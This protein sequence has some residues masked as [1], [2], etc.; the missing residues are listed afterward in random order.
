MRRNFYFKWVCLGLCFFVGYGA[1]WGQQ[2]ESE[3]NDNSNSADV[4]VFNQSISGTIF[5]EGDED[6]FE[7]CVTEPGVLKV[8]GTDPS[9]IIE[10][11]VD[12]ISPEPQLSDLETVIENNS[13]GLLGYWKICEPGCY[14]VRAYDSGF[15]DESTDSYSITLSYNQDDIYECNESAGVSATEIQIGETIQANIFPEGD[16]DVFKV[17]VPRSGI[18]EISATNI[19]SDNLDFELIVLDENQN[20]L[21]PQFQDNNAGGFSHA[22]KVCEAGC[23]YFEIYDDGGADFSSMLFDFTVGFNTEDILECNDS[24]GSNLPLLDCDTVYASIYPRYSVNTGSD[25]D[26]YR[27]Q[28]NSAGVYTFKVFDISPDVDF[29]MKIYDQQGGQQG[30]TMS[31]DNGFDII[32]DVPLPSSGTYL[33]EIYDNG[34][35]DVSA[36]LY[37]LVVPLNFPCSIGPGGSN[38]CSVSINPSSTSATCNQNDGT[39][40]LTTS[41]GTAPY[42]YV[43]NG[44]VNDS[45]NSSSTSV[46][47]SNLPSG[48]YTAQVTD[49]E[50]CTASVNFTITSTG[51]PVVPNF[52]YTVNGQD[53]SFD[54]PLSSLDMVDSLEWDF[55]DGTASND[56]FS[57]HT[58]AGS[59]PYTVS[60]QFWNNCG[61]DTHDQ[62]VSLVPSVPPNAAFTTSSNKGCAPFTV[63]FDNTSTNAIEYQWIIE[64]V[65]PSYY[66]TE[67]VGNITFNTPGI[68]TV[69]L[70]AENAVGEEDAATRIIEVQELPVADF[71]VTVMGNQA[72][73]TN[74]SS[75]TPLI[76]DYSWSFGD[77]L[78]STAINPVH[79]YQQTGFYSVE[80]SASNT[81]GS[82]TAQTE[83]QA[84]AP[85]GIAT[86][87]I[88]EAEGFEGTTVQ[89][90]VVLSGLNGS[91]LASVQGTFD[92]ED[93]SVGNI[94]SISPALLA[95]T[96]IDFNSS[97]DRFSA[98]GSINTNLNGQ[99]TLFYLEVFL[100]GEPGDTSEITISTSPNAGTPLE[101]SVFE[102]GVISFPDPLITVPGRVSIY[103]SADVDGQVTY[104]WNGS[105]VNFTEVNLDILQ[106]ATTPD[107]LQIT[108]PDGLYEFDNVDAGND[109]EI[110]CFKDTNYLNGVSTAPL[111]LI[112]E[113]IVDLDTNILSS[114]YQLVAA[115]A[116]CDRAVT[117]SDIAAFQFLIVG[118]TNS[119]SCGA[120]W[121]FIPESYPI[122]YANA[123]LYPNEVLFNDILGDLIAD[124]IGVKLGDLLGLA[125][126]SNLTDGNFPE[127]RNTTLNLRAKDRSL[128]AG[129]PFQIQLSTDDFNEIA[130]LQFALDYATSHLEFLGFES[131]DQALAPVQHHNAEEGSIRLSWLDQAANGV[132]LPDGES[133]FTL[134]FVAHQPIASLVD[135]LWLNPNRLRSEAMQA[136]GPISDVQ[137]QWN[138]PTSI[139]DTPSA[140]RYILYQNVPNPAEDYT[141]IPFRLPNAEQGA[142]QLIG[143]FGNIIA[144]YE[145]SFSKGFHE[146][147]VQTGALPAGVY[148]YRLITPNFTATRS[149]SIN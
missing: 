122:N 128:A 64:G 66:E 129:E 28:I 147:K 74:L 86:L 137:L 112:Q 39:V 136:G 60:L 89:V 130:S 85:L 90:P 120:S 53:V 140:D 2:M 25:Y 101:V 99:D 30:S 16:V 127:N 17:C 139:L 67:E 146:F 98:L 7:I 48:S 113:F 59:G 119:L 23:Y 37:K 43:L 46:T 102:N 100:S 125:D 52:D 13:G 78:T 56:T 143:Q 58:Y 126:P 87:D 124:F 148:Y 142:I 104:W 44:P 36:Q 50:M 138:T 109:V 82:S 131:D 117:T 24:P 32:E 40:S 15:G 6:W 54:F 95:A 73:F 108:G 18:F 38:I 35:A 8:E 83:I 118:L 51:G 34:G 92:M 1:A 110:Y 11:R 55:G 103:P 3:N 12:I 116:N 75:P 135:Y 14:Y 76:D 123:L 71:D 68:Y 70:I 77:G 31:S 45:Q 97:G 41:G 145:G 115:D 61:T 149:M 49:A 9:N 29:R 19:D 72:S 69:T 10:F 88:G 63:T 134:R 42:N 62:V 111:F 93:P 105:G 133:V 132:T 144:T 27:F 65:Q 121:K 84:S 57:T 96:G 79:T 26:Y 22:F 4:V 106:T 20:I 81:C 33:I 107:S 91:I 141:R 47:F 5:P 94:T 80:L 21:S 114:P